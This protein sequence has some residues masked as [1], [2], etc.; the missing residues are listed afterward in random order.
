L[1]PAAL[2]GGWWLCSVGRPTNQRPYWHCPAFFG[3]ASKVGAAAIPARV[4]G[5][6]RIRMRRVRVSKR[7]E[8]ALRLLRPPSPPPPPSPPL[9]L[10]LLPS[11]SFLIF[12]QRLPPP[13]SY[14]CSVLV[15]V[16]SS[17]GSPPVSSS[18]P[19][20]RS[21]IPISE[22]ILSAGPYLLRAA[23]GPQPK[24]G[25]GPASGD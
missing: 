12:L 9:L 11:S 16:N 14:I 6:A 1:T 17:D 20:L 10:L 4:A 13:I 18:L 22:A 3:G 23:H 24:Q 5:G 21:S 25:R 7:T 15:L 19:S 2:P 8:R